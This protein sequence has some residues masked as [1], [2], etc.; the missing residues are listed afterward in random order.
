MT[1]SVLVCALLLFFVCFGC[2]YR[3]QNA[4][5]ISNHG[6]QQDLK[7]IVSPPHDKH[8]SKE[9]TLEST[10]QIVEIMPVQEL[11]LFSQYHVSQNPYTNLPEFDTFQNEAI[12][13]KNDDH[14][15]LNEIE[16]R[17]GNRASMMMMAESNTEKLPDPP[18]GQ[19]FF[20]F[21]D[22]RGRFHQGYTDSSGYIH[23]GVF[24]EDGNFNFGT[25]GESLAVRVENEMFASFDIITAEAVDEKLDIDDNIIKETALSVL[26]KNQPGMQSAAESMIVTG[27]VG[28]SQKLEH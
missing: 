9:S 22:E 2:N 13:D 5:N 15:R 12:G 21:W 17:A 24:D 4:S 14:F 6:E 3:R 8:S 10:T 19:G 18:R 1:G 11:P 16:T 28:D 20:A 25:F 23:G 7:I 27:S 26:V